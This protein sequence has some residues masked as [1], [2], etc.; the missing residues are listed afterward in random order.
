MTTVVGEER[1]AAKIYTIAAVTNVLLNL[2]AIPRFGY[3]GAAAVTVLT[4][5]IAS[6]LFYLLLSHKLHLPEVR[7]IFLRV[8]AAS[9]LMGGAVYLARSQNFFIMIALGMIVYA[10]LAFGFRL[11]DQSEWGLIL[12]L[13]HREDSVPAE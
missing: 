10:G 5:L 7:G 12:R 9:T 2:I 1:N 3:L 8:V 4:D 11:L 13:F 6:I